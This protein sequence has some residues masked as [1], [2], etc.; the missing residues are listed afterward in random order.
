MKRT[1]LALAITATFS[2]AV[3]ADGGELKLS[4]GINKTR[5]AAFG[6]WA[7]PPLPYT[8]DSTD[9]TYAVEF[10]YNVTPWLGATVGV[11]DRGGY[12]ASGT[13][14][15]DDCF[16]ASFKSSDCSRRFRGSVSGSTRAATLTLDPTWRITERFKLYGQFGKSFYDARFQYKWE[17]WGD[18]ADRPCAGGSFKRIGNSP[19]LALGFE[20]RGVSVTAYSASSE[21]APQSIGRG[22][23]GARLG[24]S[25]KL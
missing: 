22:N 21:T 6:A 12:S 1:A 23:Y 15:S 24:Y 5:Q 19:Y 2:G 25:W 14:V 13:Y 16:H 18:C 9:K 10:T 17:A 8:F 20:Y 7:Q 11:A 3:G 4:Y